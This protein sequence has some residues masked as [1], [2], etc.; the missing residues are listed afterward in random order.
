M[1]RGRDEYSRRARWCLWHAMDSDYWWS[2][3]WAPEIIDTW[4]REF[5]KLLR[6]RIESIRVDEIRVLD[7]P[8][9]GSVSRVLIR[10]TNKC[11][12]E[13]HAS[14]VIGGLGI[15]VEGSGHI[16][17]IAIKPSSSYDRVVRLRFLHWGKALISV[18]VI[19]AGYI[20]DT[21][22]VLVGVEPYVRPNP[23]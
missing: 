12:R 9:E 6:P 20:I 7:K 1:I 5:D 4:I 16:K 2:E 13:V 10:V 14:I 19:V 21:R 17:P 3:F 22:S 15:E 8:C 18:A 23:V 11:D